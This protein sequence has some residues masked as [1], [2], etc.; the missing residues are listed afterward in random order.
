[1]SDV[2]INVS[3]MI[4]AAKAE[5]PSDFQTA[6]N[7]IIIDKVAAALEAKRQEV[8]QNY[9]NTSA[10]Q[11]A[12][13]QEENTDENIEANTDVNDGSEENGEASTNVAG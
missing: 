10:E 1:M 13:D 3:D 5:S 12:E 9:F 2:Q 4:A 11:S 6:F 7:S 8:A